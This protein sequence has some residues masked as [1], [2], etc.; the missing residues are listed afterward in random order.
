M[1]TSSAPWLNRPWQL[2]LQ[3]YRVQTAGVSAQTKDHMHLSRSGSL[4]TYH[5]R[6]QPA[7]SDSN[8][9]G[10]RWSPTLTFFP[11]A[12]TETCRLGL[13]NSLWSWLRSNA[14]IY[15][16]TT[17]MT[18]LSLPFAPPCF[19]KSWGPQ[20]LLR[21]LLWRKENVCRCGDGCSSWSRPQLW[22]VHS[23]PGE[24]DH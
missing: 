7:T 8:A 24:G 18:V 19:S 22:A 14:R 10:L 6:T 21:I 23:Y 5:A 15:C 16:K 11:K 13:K 12:R 1:P 4:H 9:V 20:V 3:L 2:Q 17:I